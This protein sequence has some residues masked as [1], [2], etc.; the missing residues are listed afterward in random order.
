MIKTITPI[1]NTIYVERNYASSQE[2]E[3]TLNISKKTFFDWQNTS[4]NERKKILTKFV[5]SFL[6]N[7]KEIEE[8]LCRQMGRPIDQCGGE[9]NGFE[10]R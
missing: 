6:E 3:N 8:E 4:I 5:D 1:D 2:I 7:K 9:M 10:E